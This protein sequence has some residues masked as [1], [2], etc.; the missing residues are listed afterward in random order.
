M[1]LSDAGSRAVYLRCRKN[2]CLKDR[3]LDVLQTI[4]HSRH[5]HID[6]QFKDVIKALWLE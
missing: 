6:K 5:G 3:P 1:D 2:A 4:H